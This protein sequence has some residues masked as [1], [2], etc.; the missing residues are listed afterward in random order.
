MSIQITETVLKNLYDEMEPLFPDSCYRDYSK[1]KFRIGVQV[2]SINENDKTLFDVGILSADRK[3][4]AIQEAKDWLISKVALE[5]EWEKRRKNDK[6][7]GTR[8][9]AIFSIIIAMMIALLVIN[10]APVTFALILKIL[11]FIIGVPVIG[12]M[13]GMA[14]MW[15]LLLITGIDIQNLGSETYVNGVPKG[16]NE[17]LG[18]AK[19]RNR[20]MNYSL[21]LGFIFSALCIYVG[22]FTQYPISVIGVYLFVKQIALEIFHL[23]R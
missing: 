12:I 6:R 18:V 5:K 15:L 9:I 16:E 1:H 8:N 21:A 3:G 7:K 13:A 4:L 14:L 17:E 23:L 2:V 10:N 11:V 20:I 22:L 19:I